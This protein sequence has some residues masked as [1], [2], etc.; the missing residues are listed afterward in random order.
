MFDNKICSSVNFIDLHRLS[1]SVWCDN[2]L[3]V[4]YTAYFP[5][6]IAVVSLFYSVLR[7]FVSSQ[8]HFPLE[9]LPAEVASKRF[10]A[11][12]FTA[13]SYEI[14]ALTEGFSADLALVW[15]LTCMNE[16]VFFHV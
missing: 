14:G 12:V 6:A 8:V 13:V 7:F 5:F 2:R 16:G 3:Q 15:L 1:N 9:P 11:G 4:G 10:E